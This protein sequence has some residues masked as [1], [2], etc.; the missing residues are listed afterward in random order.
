M[1]LGGKRLALTGKLFSVILNGILVREHQLKR[2][3][4]SIPKVLPHPVKK[5]PFQGQPI[6]L[7]GGIQF[8]LQFR[9][10]LDDDPAALT[11]GHIT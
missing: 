1:D 5:P 9:I 6:A 3:L 8:L 2:Q 7:E 10:D 11:Y 4:I